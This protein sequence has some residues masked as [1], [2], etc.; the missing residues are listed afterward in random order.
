MSSVNVYY[1]S[2]L[3]ELN[4]DKTSRATVVIILNMAVQPSCG[5]CYFGLAACSFKAREYHSM[6]RST[7]PQQGPLIIESLRR[8]GDCQ[9]ILSKPDNIY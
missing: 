4:K 1:F 8:N 7:I 9:V 3:N 6:I 5:C 2:K